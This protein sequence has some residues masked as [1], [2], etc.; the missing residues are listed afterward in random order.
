MQVARKEACQ[1]HLGKGLCCGVGCFL[2]S[3]AAFFFSPS[4]LASAFFLRFLRHRSTTFFS[5]HSAVQLAN[6]PFGVSE[7]RQCGHRQSNDPRVR[8]S[9]QLSANCAYSFSNV[10]IKVNFRSCLL[11]FYSLDIRVGVCSNL[12]TNLETFVK[13]STI[14]FC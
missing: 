6:F 9:A 2:R 12:E 13:I 10:S 4:V 8:Y 14:F 3:S 5:K 7:S 1:L 11:V